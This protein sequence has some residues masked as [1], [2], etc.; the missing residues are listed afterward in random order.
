MVIKKIKKHD[1]EKEF[2]SR[3]VLELGTGL[4]LVT[5]GLFDY[6]KQTDVFSMPFKPFFPIPGHPL[7]PIGCLMASAP[8]IY[9]GINN[10]NKCAKS[11]NA[12]QR[13]EELKEVM[14]FKEKVELI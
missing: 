14:F 4:F 8:L 11:H 7:V 2:K 3:Y 5:Y 1:K 6:L 12:R 9:M 10:I 13:K